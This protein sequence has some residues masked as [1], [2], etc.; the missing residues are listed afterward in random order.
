MY[1]MLLLIHSSLSHQRPAKKARPVKV[2]KVCLCLL[3]DLILC[4]KVVNFCGVQIIVD[5]IKLSY[6]Q[7]LLTFI[8][9]VFK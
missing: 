8:Y 6:P 5:F 3:L 2:V 7:K 4:R 1:S 9:T